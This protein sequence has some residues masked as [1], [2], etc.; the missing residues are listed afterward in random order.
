ML[1]AEEPH[2]KRGTRVKNI[3]DLCTEHNCEIKGATE[4]PAF[5]HSLDAIQDEARKI[6]EGEGAPEAKFFAIAN[7][8]ISECGYAKTRLDATVAFAKNMGYKKVGVAFCISFSHE[9]EIVCKYLRA[10]GL[11]V[12]SAV[13]KTGANAGD[14]NYVNCNPVAQALL[15]NEAGTELNIELGLCVGHDALFSKYS[16]APVT[17]LFTKEH[18]SD[19]R[20]IDSVRALDNK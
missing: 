4:F 9:A 19:N 1:T 3:C 20:V 6:C 7:R 17:T 15:L 10:C 13:C 11:S 2:K 5:C 18:C 16:E 8:T 14:G 12:E